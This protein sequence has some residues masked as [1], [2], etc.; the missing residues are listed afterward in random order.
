MGHYLSRP[1]ENS[2][3]SLKVKHSI[4]KVKQME[5]VIRV[6]LNLDERGSCL[7]PF[8]HSLIYYPPP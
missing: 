4:I 7:S 8:L 1:I 3:I 2:I 5:K 6:E